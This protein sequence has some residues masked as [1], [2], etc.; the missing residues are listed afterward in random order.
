[1]TGH[2]YFSDQM[3]RQL[4]DPYIEVENDGDNTARLLLFTEA[5]RNTYIP[6]DGTD[7]D[8][9]IL[10]TETGKTAPYKLYNAV[11]QYGLAGPTWDR[12][13]LLMLQPYCY[14]NHCCSC[15]RKQYAECSGLWDGEEELA[16]EDD[17]CTGHR[18][19]FVQI[20]SPLLPDL[21]L[22]SETMSEDE[23]NARLLVPA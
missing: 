7:L 20:T 1:M 17:L 16:N 23:L 11:D 3:H 19:K 15:H 22:Y 6:P 21:I 18:F 14:Q 13:D 4:D 5:W 2:P 9:I 10:D 8:C 12:G